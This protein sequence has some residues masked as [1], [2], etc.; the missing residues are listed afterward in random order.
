VS[1][2]TRSCSTVLSRLLT[3]SSSNSDRT[4]IDLP[5]P[6]YPRAACPI[7]PILSDP[8]AVCPIRSAYRRDSVTAARN[9]SQS[10]PDERTSNAVISFSGGG[11]ST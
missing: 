1:V 10:S 8:R 6:I 11:W 3:I 5:Y 2:L 7:R 9:G 4:D